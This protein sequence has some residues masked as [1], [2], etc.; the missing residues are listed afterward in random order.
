MDKDCSRSIRSSLMNVRKDA[1]VIVDD[2][3]TIYDSLISGDIAIPQTGNVF[4]LLFSSHIPFHLL[5][6]I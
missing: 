5:Q 3:T 2:E 6:V 1:I 4:N